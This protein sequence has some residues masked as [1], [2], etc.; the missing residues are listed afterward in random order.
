M[1]IYKSIE[2]INAELLPQMRQALKKRA[3]Q[4]TGKAKEEM[5]LI[6]KMLDPDPA[7]RL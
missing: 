6:H 1:G 2:E 4:L 5:N 3:D 7:T